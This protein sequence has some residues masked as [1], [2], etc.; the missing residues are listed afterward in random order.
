M[1]ALLAVTCFPLVLS[2]T[3]GDY[4]RLDAGEALVELLPAESREVAVRA[5]T[6][7]DTDP[8][9]LIQWTRRVEELNKGRYVVAIGRFSAP[10]RIED[11]DGLSLD[12]GDLTDLRRCR[13]GKCGVKLNDAEI[14]RMHDAIATAGGDWKATAQQTFRG[15]VLARAQDYLAGGHTPSASYHDGKRPAQLHS[16][17][18]ALASEVELTQPRLFPIVN[19]LS[20]YPKGEMPGVESFLYWSKESLGAKP[21]IGITHV[22]MIESTDAFVREALVAKKQVYASHYVLA[23]LSFTVINAS[24]DASRHYLVYLNRSRSDVFDGLFGGFIRRTIARRLRA[25]APEALRVL[26]QRLESTPP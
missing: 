13:P 23:S 25:E 2:L 1:R 8:A 18:A 9:R 11:V 4:T 10:P 5:A 16:E 12:E 3:A 24:P 15:I 7:I 22:A 21:I 17:F 20:L 6:G 14:A 19:Y 26:R